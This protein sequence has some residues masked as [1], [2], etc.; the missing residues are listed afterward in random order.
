MS[1]ETS[2]LGGGAW[3]PHTPPPRLVWAWPDLDSRPPCCCLGLGGPQG[4]C[5]TAPISPS[6]RLCRPLAYDGVQSI[7][8][9]ARIS[10]CNSNV[11]GKLGVAG[12]PC[13]EHGAPHP[14]PQFSQAAPPKGRPK[15]KY[16]NEMAPLASPDNPLP[17]PCLGRVVRV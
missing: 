10:T 12:S 2:R 1:E 11:L 3:L 16:C 14:E 13:L 7:Q 6:H 15:I 8:P 17:I 5:S 9:C 4:C